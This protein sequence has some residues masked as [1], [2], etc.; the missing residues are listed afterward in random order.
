MSEEQI[1]L[2]GSFFNTEDVDRLTQ[3][4]TNLIAGKEIT[5]ASVLVIVTQ[6]MVEAAKYVNLTGMQKKELILYVLRKFVKQ[7]SNIPQD[8]KKDILVMFDVTIPI[9][10]DLLV[11]ASKSKFV[12]KIKKSILTCCGCL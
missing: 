2:D 6:L 3:K 9:T 4:L 8:S 11:S 7:A 12:F 5:T 10:I 1:N